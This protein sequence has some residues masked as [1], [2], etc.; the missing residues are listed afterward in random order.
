MDLVMYVHL[1]QWFFNLGVITPPG[2]KWP[3]PSSH[4][5]LSDNTRLITVAKLV[6]KYQ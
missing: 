5:K 2:V 6:M 4:P 3:F 1:E